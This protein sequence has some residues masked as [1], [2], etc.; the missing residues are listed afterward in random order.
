MNAI[1]LILAS[2]ANAAYI[3]KWSDYQSASPFI[4]SLRCIDMVKINGAFHHKATEETEGTSCAVFF[5][6]EID[7][8]LTL[9]VTALSFNRNSDEEYI[10]FYDGWD[11]NGMLIPSEQPMT[12]QPDKQFN[13]KHRTFDTTHNAGMIVFKLK[14]NSSFRIELH[15]NKAIESCGAIIPRPTGVYS[16]QGGS[17]QSCSMHLIYPSDIIVRSLFL[18]QTKSQKKRTKAVIKSGRTFS[19]ATQLKVFKRSLTGSKRISVSDYTTITLQSKNKI[20]YVKF[21]VREKDR[22]RSRIY[23]SS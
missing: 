4:R 23:R 10:K 22:A 20:D 12:K 8:I 3:S 13:S 17:Q 9:T 16:M 19:E 7:E 1:A 14:R 5:I 15:T 6:G 11:I 18:Q 21:E 2:L